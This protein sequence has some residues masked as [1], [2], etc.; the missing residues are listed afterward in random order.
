M[1]NL[2][3]MAPDNEKFPSGP[4]NFSEN[5]ATPEQLA[6]EAIEAGESLAEI[7]QSPGFSMEDKW[8]M[9]TI[10][11]ELTSEHGGPI[12]TLTTEDL[13]EDYLLLVEGDM[14]ANSPHRLVELNNQFHELSLN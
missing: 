12:S 4:E 13:M 9:A 3:K 8:K 5:L 11:N 6:P 1:A 14:A 2:E 10:A 7:P